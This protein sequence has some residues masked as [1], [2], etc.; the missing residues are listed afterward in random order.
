MIIKNLEYHKQELHKISE[1]IKQLRKDSGLP[2]RSGDDIILHKLLKNYQ[3]WVTRAKTNKNI[4]RA[5]YARKKIKTFY[6]LEISK[7]HHQ[8]VIIALIKNAKNTEVKS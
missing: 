7:A 2:K 5:K 1:Q 8:A 3:Y 4:S 6:R